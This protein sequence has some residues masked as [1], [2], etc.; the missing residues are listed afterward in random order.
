MGGNVKVRSGDEG[1]LFSL[2]TS[3]ILSLFSCPQYFIWVLKSTE[4]D[5]ENYRYV[6]NKKIKRIIYIRTISVFY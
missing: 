2:V 3:Y 1:L 6:K 4:E 5:E